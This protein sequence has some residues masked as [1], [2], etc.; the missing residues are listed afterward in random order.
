MRKTPTLMLLGCVLAAGAR[1]GERI[2]FDS[3]WLFRLGDPKGAESASFGTDGWRPV[4]VPHDWSIGGVPSPDAP[5]SEGGGYFPTGVGWYRKVLD[6]PAAWRGRTVRIVFDGVY[7]DSQVWVNGVSLGVHPYGFTPFAYDL[8]AN[9]RLGGGNVIAVRVDNSRQPNCRW[10]SG[11]GIYRHVAIEVLDPVHIEPLSTVVRTVSADPDSASVQ[12]DAVVSND[13]EAVVSPEVDVDIADPRGAPES[14]VEVARAG[15]IAPGSSAEIHETVTVRHPRMWSPDSP[16]LSQARVRVLVAG[17]EADRVSVPFG[18]RTLSVTAERGLEINGRPV[19]LV[20]GAEHHDNGPLGAAALDRAEERRVEL[21]KGAGFN[22]VRTSHNPPSPA[23]LDACDRLGILVMDEAFDGWEKP[24]NPDDYNLYFRDW[25]RRDL[26][27]MVERDRN[28]PSVVLWSIGNEVYERGNAEGA[29]IARM[30]ATR[31]RELDPT[32]PV[33][34]GI[35]GLGKSGAWTQLDPLFSALDVAGYNYQLAQIPGDHERLPGRIIVGTESYQSAT[36]EAWAASQDRPYVL[37]DFAWCALDYLGE[38]GIGKVFPPGQAVVPHWAGPQFPW[39]GAECGDIDLTGWRKPVSHYRSIVWDRGESLYMAATAPAPGGGTWVQSKW[40]MPPALPSWTWPGSE[41]KPIVVEVYS[42]HPR[43]TL[44]LNGRTLGA[45]PTT[46]A[47]EFKAVFSVPYEPGTLIAVGDGDGRPAERF[48]LATAGP[49][50]RV[51][52]TA[53]RAGI[54][55]D[56]S[57]LSFVTVEVTDWRG[58]PRPDLDQ[59]VRFK[60][61][62]PGT[63]AGIGNADMTDLESYQANPHRTYQGRAI[64]IVRSTRAPGTVILSASAPGLGSRPV[65]INTRPPEQP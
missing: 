13:S 31:V 3:A 65:W 12:V 47:E 64:V 41:G 50:A 7:M 23:F 8:T 16:S 57:D 38:A 36:F 53:D 9:L 63:I 40:S 43:V 61:E 14:E 44:S 22:A 11:S 49:P 25:W 59:A 48:E 17:R 6:A 10:Y 29:R 5:S 19:K 58:R 26:D 46:R 37:G 35:N 20:G 42:R 39:H 56:G 24:K 51:R 28:H 27:A 33:A 15:Q 21:L 2:A 18:I 52:L 32:R 4:D 1:A 45:K 62:G 55:A 60:V 54:L 34:S 30:L